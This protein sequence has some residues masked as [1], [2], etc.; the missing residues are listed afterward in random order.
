MKYKEGSVCYL[1]GRKLVRPV[2]GKIRDDDFTCDHKIPRALGGN[3]NQNNTAPCCRRCNQLK[4]S[5]VW[6]NN[7]AILMK[8]LRLCEKNFKVSSLVS[9][10]PDSYE[11]HFKKHPSVRI[12]FESNKVRLE[13]PSGGDDITDTVLKV[14]HKQA[15][16]MGI[17]IGM[18]GSK[19][20]AS[21]L[22]NCAICHRLTKGEVYDGVLICTECFEHLK[23]IKVTLKI[24]YDFLNF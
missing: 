12:V 11:L 5:I 22:S 20:A 19:T 21:R 10:H 15:K 16:S 7:L 3:N 8:L 24:T 1:C 6:S 14:I 17:L 4:S 2:M 18:K 9:A 13:L 23:Q